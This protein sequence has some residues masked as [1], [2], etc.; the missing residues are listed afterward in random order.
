MQTTLARELT[1]LLANA[2]Q[3]LRWHLSCQQRLGYISELKCM[4]AK[5]GLASASIAA[6]ENP[7]DDFVATHI[8]QIRD[9]RYSCSSPPAQDVI[10]NY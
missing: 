7:Y 1:H 9:V 8:V 6:A 2:H 3:P 5:P 10:K 4:M